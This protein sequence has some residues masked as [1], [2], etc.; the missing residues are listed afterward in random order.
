M[1]KKYPY[2]LF[3]C[4]FV[5]LMSINTNAQPTEKEAREILQKI[6]QSL[7]TIRSVVYKID[8]S[9]KYLSKRDTIRTTAI[10]S[11]YIAPKDKMKA[12]SIVDLR[13]TEL[14]V[15]KYGHRRYDGKKT[16]WVNYLVDSLDMAIKPFIDGNGRTRQGVVENYNKLLLREY[17][18]EKK[19]FK[20]YQPTAGNIKITEEIY[21][22]NPVYVLQLTFKDREEIRDNFE[23]HYIRKSDFL[24]VAY[25]NFLR[26]ENM[27]QYNYYEVEYL[28]INPD[29]SVEDFKIDKNETIN[30]KERY[31]I[32]K[33]KAGI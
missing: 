27:E 15:E 20:K 11:L 22:G 33:E 5:L 29:F 4:L 16:F 19:P 32:L 10:C 3:N 28:A 7:G 24:P 12:Y 9:N 2:L 25:T 14:K 30:A 26:F 18:T 31:A 8:Y 17:L 21:K 13:F 1:N 6:D 23:K